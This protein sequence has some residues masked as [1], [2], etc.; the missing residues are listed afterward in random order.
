MARTSGDAHASMAVSPHEISTIPMG[1]EPRE[2]AKLAPKSAHTAENESKSSSRSPERLR[3]EKI[4]RKQIIINTNIWRS[5]F[6]ERRVDVVLGRLGIARRWLENSQ[7]RIGRDSVYFLSCVQ[8]LLR[9]VC[10]N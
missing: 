1:R 6:G 2:S 4:R 9:E 8:N 5:P 7:L 10:F 3:D